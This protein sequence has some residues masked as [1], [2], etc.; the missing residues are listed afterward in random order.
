MESKPSPA[1]NSAKSTTFDGAS[2]HGFND[3]VLE[4]ILGKYID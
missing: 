4:G 1:P 2:V 3:G